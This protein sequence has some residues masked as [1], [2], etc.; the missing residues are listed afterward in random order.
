MSKTAADVLSLVADEG[1][2][3]VDLRFC[4]LP[5]QVQ[6]FTVPV[7]Q[8]TEDSFEAGFGFDGS[9]IRGFQQ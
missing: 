9:S 1:Y 8:L 4:D 6:H 7:K 3:F 5:G 2:E